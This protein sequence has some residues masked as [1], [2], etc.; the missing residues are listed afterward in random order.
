MA[1]TCRL[2]AGTLRLARG[3][4]QP[5]CRSQLSATKAG[6]LGPSF[7]IHVPA[8]ADPKHQVALVRS[9]VNDAVVSNAKPVES[10]ELRRKSLPLAA[11]LN[12]CFFDFSENPKRARL[13]ELPEIPLDGGLVLNSYGQGASVALPPRLP[14]RP[15]P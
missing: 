6:D 5:P 4:A 2:G 7:S 15:C 3:A 9:C 14:G 10:G 8:V 12:K 11:F 1:A 13:A